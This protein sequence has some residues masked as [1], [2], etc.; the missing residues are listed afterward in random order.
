MEI[1]KKTTTYYES[2]SDQKSRSPAF[3]KT[4]EEPRLPTFT[5]EVLAI[6]PKPF[7]RNEE[8]QNDN[9]FMHTSELTSDQIHEQAITEFNNFTNTL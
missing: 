9:L 2:M 6:R 4:E 7:Y 1:Q 5:N 8:T 3:Q